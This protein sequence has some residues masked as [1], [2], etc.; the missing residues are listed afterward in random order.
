MPVTMS[1]SIAVLKAGE[2][3]EILDPVQSDGIGQRKD[4]NDAD[5]AVED[6]Q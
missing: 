6:Q 1:V 5:Q 2:R 4:E 3:P